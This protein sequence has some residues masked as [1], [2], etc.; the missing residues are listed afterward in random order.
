MSD[1]VAFVCN[2]VEVDVE[3]VPGESLLSVL[4]ERLGI[5]SA[6]DGCAPQ[7]QCGCCTVLVDGTARV[8]CVTPVTRITG[9]AVTTIEGLD[10]VTRAILAAAFVETG[11]SQCGFCTPGIVMRVAPLC[12]DGL[13]SR[14]ALDRA[15][16]AH[17]CRCTGWQSVYAAA[18]LA[19]S[20]SGSIP[21]SPQR[22]PTRGLTDAADRARLEG[23]A[24]QL[25]SAEVPLGHG[26]FAD[27]LAPRDAWVAVPAPEDSG[28]VTVEAAGM[29][30]IVAESLAAAR[31]LAA[32][33]HGRRTTAPDRP[34]LPLPAL[35]V[36]GVRLATSWC[37]PAYLEPDASWC[38]PGGAPAMVLANGGAFGA[39]L[40]SPAPRA[41]RA[42]ADHLGRSVR[43]VF[44]REDVVRH[45]PKRPPM[46][47]TAVLDGDTLRVEGTVVG[48]VAAFEVDRPS[49]YRIAQRCVW[50]TAVVPG[51][52]VSA[53]LRAVGLAERAVLLEGALDVAGAERNELLA[54]DRAG[55]VLLDT[56]VVVPGDAM[57]GAR[58]QFDPTTGALMRVEV[59][60][61]AGDP[62]DESV[63]VDE[64]T[65]EVLDLTIRSFGVIRAKDT[66][67]IEITIVD[68]PGAARPRASDAVFAAVAAAA[69]NAVT[70]VDGT[71]PER[72]PA[73]ETRA[74][75][76]LRR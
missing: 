71:R 42:L 9:R 34:P 48:M 25:V 27:D 7:G 14:P 23:G 19:G 70:V 54:D 65:G 43:V 52:A 2:G 62:L 29:R 58:V 46:A 21:A 64:V 75:R 61:A 5:V 72:F 51:P 63:A 10:A 53:D 28:A 57:A 73:S 38:E 66:P 32:N 12:A 55:S 37:E 41:A 30:W 15:L 11:G 36:G 24:P 49:P 59:R 50:R 22:G 60:V 44:S 20:A 45:G 6:K 33:V 40:G 3:V 17:L 67:P 76:R 18:E 69:W 74:A 35:P 16:A 68:D 31:K 8:S 56:C 39:K 4:R 13:P 26:G 47:A 1:R